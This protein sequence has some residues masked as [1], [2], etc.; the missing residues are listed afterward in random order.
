MYKY[1]GIRKI[2]AQAYAYDNMD[3]CTVIHTISLLT[4]TY[5]I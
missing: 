2:S 1:Y 3:I 5:D 4:F